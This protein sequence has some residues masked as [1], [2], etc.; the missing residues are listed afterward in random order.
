M[1]L[2]LAA[3]HPG[4]F[5]QVKVAHLMSLHVSQ[6]AFLEIGHY[7]VE[8]FVLCLSKFKGC[9]Y[10]HFRDLSLSYTFTNAEISYEEE[11]YKIDGDFHFQ[12]VS[13]NFLSLFY[14]I[15]STPNYDEGSISFTAC[16]IP[17]IPQFLAHDSLAVTNIDECSLRN[18]L[19]AWDGYDL[20]IR[21]CPSFND[22]FI[23]WLGTQVDR[24]VNWKERP[25]KV[26]RLE[27]LNSL[28]IEDCSNFTPAV[29]WAFVEARDNGAL[30]LHP[31]PC[32]EPIKWLEV[33]ILPEIRHGS[34]ELQKRLQ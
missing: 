12:S 8:N 18:I 5:S 7:T 22:T 23:T 6:F 13:H 15:S 19:M 24:K 1:H 29:L 33:S 28:R 14:A 2:A 30:S 17:T 32:E 3:L 34:C 25:I 20:R 4:W 11:A 16:Q 10:R 26:F 9:V 31:Q 21:S 27:S